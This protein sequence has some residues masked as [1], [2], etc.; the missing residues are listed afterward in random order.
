MK[1]V[2]VL[3]FIL[4]TININ[5]QQPLAAPSYNWK[6]C[7]VTQSDGNFFVGGRFTQS[8]VPFAHPKI[9]VVNN[10]LTSNNSLGSH[11]FGDTEQDE[12]FDVENYNSEILQRN[13]RFRYV[14]GSVYFY[15]GVYVNG[16]FRI[17]TNGSLDPNFT[18]NNN[19][20]SSNIATI[21]SIAIQSNN[22]IVLGGIFN[23]Y[24]GSARKNIVRLNE[25]GTLDTSFN[26]VGT[27]FNGK[28]NVV[29]IQS[30]GKILVGGE[31]TS[32]NG[33]TLG[34]IARLNSNGSLDTTFSVNEGFNDDVRAIAIRTDNR[35]LVGG[36]FTK[37]QIF[38]V[39]GQQTSRNKI[40]CLDTNGTLYTAFDPGSGF[41]YNGSNIDSRVHT[42]T[43][44]SSKVFIGGTFTSYDIDPRVNVCLL[45]SFGGIET[46]FNPSSGP[47]GAVLDSQFES[48]T[49]NFII[50]GGFYKYNNIVKNGIARI[51]A[52]GS[53]L[54]PS[55]QNNLQQYQKNLDLTE[56]TNN[57][58]LLL[59]PNPSSNIVQISGISKIKSIIISTI[60][61]KLVYSKTFE[62]E[63]DEFEINLSD[64]KS[65]IYLVRVISEKGDNFT[66]RLIKN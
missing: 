66:Q 22:K 35:V 59:S 33:V 30:D 29:K 1:K 9:A 58:R 45:N 64:F 37:H 38:T 55:N 62:N 43:I 32:Y 54:R 4:S 63:I 13:D 52:S 36:D 60:D 17:T 46:S 23:N 25:N 14:G 47:D 48:S 19:T 16:F 21:K 39:N 8:L 28:I 24:Q 34:R 53:A 31:F 57:Q 40:A 15:D 50:V 27:G 3:L 5:A 65:G 26:T 41:K 44:E 7:F 18:L 61:N 10:N 6:N 20:S 56:D 51:N 2:L 42:I 12:V 11:Q 49:G